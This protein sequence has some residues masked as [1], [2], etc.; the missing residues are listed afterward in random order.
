MPF[1]KIG[2]DS[3]PKDLLGKIDRFRSTYSDLS[4]L[5]YVSRT[6][7]ALHQVGLFQAPNATPDYEQE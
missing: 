4:N 3:C 5:G 1:P 2:R 6:W 7:I